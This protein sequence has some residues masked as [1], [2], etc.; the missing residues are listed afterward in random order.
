MPRDPF[1]PPPPDI[2]D[3]FGNVEVAQVRVIDRRKN[4]PKKDEEQFNTRAKPGIKDQIDQR[5]RELSAE[6]GRPVTRGEMLEWML[7][8]YDEK[9]NEKGFAEALNQARDDVPSAGDEAHGRTKRMQ[10]FASTDVQRALQDR[11][12][13]TG[14]TLGAVIEDMMAKAARLVHIEKK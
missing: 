12:K 13:V 4:R 9:H 8:A 11:V 2:N 5:A 1:I 7:A 14:W 10:F 6:M 3:T